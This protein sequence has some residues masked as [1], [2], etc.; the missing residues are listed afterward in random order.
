MR[1]PHAMAALVA[2]WA[3]C[4]N[5]GCSRANLDAITGV[6]AADGS[7][8]GGGGS[9]VADGGAGGAGGAGGS[10]PRT[11]PTTTL[12]AGNTTATVQVGTTNRT[13]VLHVPTAYN[14]TKPVP[15]IVDFHAIGGSGSGER[16]GSS[17]PDLVDAEGVI[18]AFPNGLS[19]PLGSAWNVGPCCVANVD[20]VAFAKA[21]VAQVKVTACIDPQRVYAVGTS[22]GGGMAYHLACHAADVFAAIAPTAFDMTE[23]SAPGCQPPRP[24]TV[25]S[26]R[27]T[28]DNIVPY[29]GGPSSFVPGMPVNFLGAKGTFDKWA[30][31]DRCPGT[32]GPED[33]NGCAHYANCQDGVEVILCTKVGGGQEVG[34]AGLAWS[35]LGKH[36]R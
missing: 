15:L 22:M 4:G 21:L 30:E 10:G 23:E 35:V 27:G 28:A 13:Y 32:A 36:T 6:P 31:I 3:A 25:I 34:N 11:C 14:G 2:L 29:A 17:Y 24:V 26:F 1:G 16:A 5:T 9:P 19:G 33:S 18:M 8:G 7:V 12:K 20:D